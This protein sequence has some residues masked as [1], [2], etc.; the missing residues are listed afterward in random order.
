MGAVKVDDICGYWLPNIAGSN[1]DELVCPSCV[2]KRGRKREEEYF[3]EEKLLTLLEV[4]EGEF[5]FFC[6]D[7]KKLISNS[8]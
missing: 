7:C 1:D 3:K 8:W 6:D 2:S 4:E 5:L